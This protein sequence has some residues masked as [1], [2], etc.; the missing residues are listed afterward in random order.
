[1]VRVL[2]TV[3]LAWLA[4]GTAGADV[5]SQSFSLPAGGGYPHDVAVGADGIV[6]YT[7]QRDGQL[8]RLDPTSGKVELIPL[9]RGSAPHGV[10]VGPDGAP[11]ITDS[12]ANAG[13]DSR[14]D[15][16]ACGR[17]LA[18]PARL[19]VR[20]LV[21]ADRKDAVLSRRIV[22]KARKAIV[23]HAGRQQCAHRRACPVRGVVGTCKDSWHSNPDRCKLHT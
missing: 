13:P 18:D 1:M 20:V 21:A 10:I 17:A 22:V 4:V 7:A 23:R 14:A 9:G 8:G 15:S 2:V 16:G 5:V 19:R 11:W 3:L 6:W 12:G